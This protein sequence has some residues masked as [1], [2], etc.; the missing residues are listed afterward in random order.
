MATIKK[1]HVNPINIAPFVDIL[2]V[3]FVILVIVA[4]FGDS[5]LESDE[6]KIALEQAKQ[7]NEQLLEKIRNFEKLS[8]A[9][10]QNLKT[11]NN[12]QEDL[13]AKNE[14]LS[15]K[16]SELRRLLEKEKILLKDVQKNLS[17]K[18]IEIEKQTEKMKSSGVYIQ[19]DSLGKIWLI[20][21]VNMKK[22]MQISPI[23]YQNIFKSLAGSSMVY[24]YDSTSQ[25]SVETLNQ[26][27]SK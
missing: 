7:D 1:Y 16:N 19:I 4:R 22:N 24:Y 13:V 5:E 27:Q 20:N 8:V 9:S 6:V 18:N 26:I 2:L 11:T 23:M 21:P 12:A 17:Q 10:S 25:R 3:I 15:K 14:E